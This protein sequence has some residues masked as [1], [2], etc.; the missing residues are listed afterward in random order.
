[1]QRDIFFARHLLCKSMDWFLYDRYLC[2]ERVKVDCLIEKKT[3]FEILFVK[4]ESFKCH[5]NSI[6]KKHYKK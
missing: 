3:Q 4:R 5:C 6:L 2:H 1:M